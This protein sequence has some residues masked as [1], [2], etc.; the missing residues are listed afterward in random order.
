MVSQMNDFSMQC[1][2]IHSFISDVLVGNVLLSFDFST[3]SAQ[4]L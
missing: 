2:I 4:T 3:V 1:L